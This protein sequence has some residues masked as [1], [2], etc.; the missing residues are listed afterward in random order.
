MA[1]ALVSAI[2]GQ[3]TTVAAEEARQQITLLANVEDEVEKIKHNLQAIK[4][5]LEDAEEKEFGNKRLQLWLDRLKEAAFDI[6]DV[7]DDWN[8]AL[9]KL[10]RRRGRDSSS[11]SSKV[12][13]CIPLHPGQAVW[14]H[15]IGSRIRQINCRLDEIA[16]QKNDYGLAERPERK[17]SRRVQTTSFDVDESN[18]FGR[19]EIKEDIINCLLSVWYEEGGVNTVS[20][21]G[22]GGVGKT[23]LAQLIYNNRRVEQ[24][25]GD[26]RTWVCVSDFFDVKNVV[27]AIIEGFEHSTVSGYD[28][29]QLQ[30]LLERLCR[31]TRGKKFLLVLD[32][33]WEDDMQKWQSLINALKHGAPG[34]RIILTTRKGTVAQ[35]LNY[36]RV[37]PLDKL[38]DHCCWMILSQLAFHG[39]DEKECAGLEDIGKKISERCKGLPLAAKTLG[40]LLRS[41]SSSREEWGK[42]LS[43]EIW[44]LDVA[45]KEIFA[46]LLLSYYDLPPPVR[47]CFKFCV[48]YPKDVFYWQLHQ[49]CK[50]MAQG[51]LELDE[52]NADDLEL[53]GVGYFSFLVSRSF[54]QDISI[55]DHV[56][57]FIKCKMHDLVH[58]FGK[59][60]AKD[61]IVV[62]EVDSEESAAINLSSNTRHLT[63]F[64]AE[65]AYPLISINGA[66]KL[67]T[68]IASNSITP[69]SLRAMFKRAKQLRMLDLSFASNSSSTN[70]SIPEEIGSLIHL[71]YLDLSCNHH[72]KKL[73]KSMRRLCNLQYLDLT[74]NTA[75]E[76]LPKWIGELS[77]LRFLQISLCTNVYHF[78]RSIR[79]LT[80]LRE[81]NGIYIKAKGDSSGE[82]LALKDLENMD[83]LRLLWIRLGG[84]VIDAEHVKRAKFDNKIHLK[85]FRIC[86]V[87]DM[88]RDYVIQALKL[89]P[90]VILRFSETLNFTQVKDV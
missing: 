14:R 41:K 69:E 79:R 5:V 17:Q 26:D 10:R 51:Y 39:R 29:S 25:F 28:D 52:N 6:E 13:S 47:Q 49:V 9:L 2:L 90:H 31:S 61:E 77:S 20:I 12:L 16:K 24:H 34:S 74:K 50:W 22:M 36:S 42:I 53:T 4:V 30:L 58:D 23:A 66:E 80:N 81:L 46:P 59:F 82:S 55:Y 38:S 48:T 67:H 40:N 60:L 73:P 33:V 84:D 68:L 62:K 8:A 43:S 32:D 64:I 18:L 75:L 15:G 35:M 86:L 72:R 1:E 37:F 44:K 71:R 87:D 56:N 19:D 83:Q 85:D 27:K 7:L 88:D 65:E 21:V 76:K 78:P 63:M 57:R 11:R 89:P 3:L 54:F 70:E 45:E